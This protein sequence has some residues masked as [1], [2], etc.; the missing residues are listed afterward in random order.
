[1]YS[2]N[3]DEWNDYSHEYKYNPDGHAS[4]YRRSELVSLNMNHMLNPKLFYELKLSYVK[5]FGGWYLYEDPTDSQYIHDAYHNIDGPGFWTGGQD[6]DHSRRTMKDYGAKFDMTWQMNK[7]HSFKFGVDYTLHNL[8]RSW[9]QIR[10][11]YDGTEQDGI[12][13]YDPIAQKIRFP[14]Y[15]AVVFPDS[16]V[17][18]DIYEVEPIEYSAYIQDK[19]EFEEMVVNVGIRYDYF[20]PSTVYPSQPRNPANQLDFTETPS[21]MSDYLDSEPKIQISPRFGLS[22][23]LGETAL[24]HFSYGHFFQMPPMFAMY[25]NRSFQISPQDYQTTLGNSE[26]KA[27]KTVQYEIGLWQELI[28]G[29]GLEVALFYRDIYDLLSAKVISTYNQIEY[30]LYSNKDYGNAKGLEIKYDVA[31]GKLSA[32][33]NYTLQYTRGN[34][35]NPT[36]TFDRA[37]DNRDPITGLIPMSWDQRHTFN[38]TVGYNESNWGVNTTGY[39]NSGT[40]YSWNPLPESILSRVNLFP[41]N[42][43]KPA[44]YTV[45]LNA[46]YDLNISKNMKLRWNLSIYNLLDNL[47]ENSVNSQ[48]GR[49]YTAIIRDNDLLSHRS[50]FN[51]YIDRIQDPAMYSAP[52]MVKLG[53][54]F[55]F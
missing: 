38:L 8:D 53:F 40:P 7:S 6:K 17:Y 16:S 31:V 55:V 52:R 15:E 23:Q 45:D 41:N 47:N 30:G 25:Q 10:N 14:N 49:A 12:F 13:E 5:N 43:Y 35:D 29:M 50:N 11:L 27:Q 1:L 54:G 2:L 42:S 21:K 26:I 46:R 9:S 19:M 51:E 34:A 37:G 18:S 39:Y 4:S 36:Q 3:D 22:Y 33:A 48:T 32:F 28:S 44:G 24:L 20:D